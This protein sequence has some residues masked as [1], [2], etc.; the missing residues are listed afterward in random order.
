MSANTAAQP[1]E[2]TLDGVRAGGARAG[3]A[4]AYFE[5]ADAHG[6]VYRFTIAHDAIDQIIGDLDRIAGLVHAERERCGK[7]TG[8]K[9]GRV[10][11]VNAVE[12]RI[13]PVDALAILNVRYS[14]KTSH[15]VPI[16]LARIP[17]AIVGLQRARLQLEG[18]SQ[19]PG[20]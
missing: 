4:A 13:A 18:L 12:L 16:P 20:H 6:N 5:A 11:E 9:R 8:L 19:T 15:D 7:P 1:I 3:G 17:S 2:I 14:D 10:K